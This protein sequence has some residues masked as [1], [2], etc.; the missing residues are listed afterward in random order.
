MFKQI[1]S[2]IFLTQYG[3]P[4]ALLLFY[5]F[6]CYLINRC[7]QS[8]LVETQDKALRRISELREQCSLEQSAKV[9][10]TFQFIKTLQLT[11]LLS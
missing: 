1:R 8:V 2:S 5:F 6:I 7:F 11:N 9:S 10:A 3:C 4:N